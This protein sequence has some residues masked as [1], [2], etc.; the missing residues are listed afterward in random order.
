M[1]R[2][3]RCQLRG[4][5]RLRPL[6]LA[7]AFVLWSGAFGVVAAC[8]QAAPDGTQASSPNGAADRLGTKLMDAANPSG[9]STLQLSRVERSR[10]TQVQR[11][12]TDEAEPSANS[13]HDSPQDVPEERGFPDASETNED[14]ATRVR[15]FSAT[16]TVRGQVRKVSEGTISL[17]NS[18]GKFQTLRGT[19]FTLGKINRGDDVEIPYVWVGNRRWLTS[20]SEERPPLEAFAVR[21][22]LHGPVTRLDRKRGMLG[23]G[24]LR[25][26]AHPHDLRT[27]AIG[28]VLRVEFVEVDQRLW[29]HSAEAAWREE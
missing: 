25:L 2:R 29:V 23:I 5:D 4:R 11:S 26:K 20:P 6:S 14:Q 17:G 7:M 21:G 1:G 27:I 28:Q 9:H 15:R 8:E 10:K 12:E 19:P 16:G 22:S 13:A 18:N 24:R 3:Q